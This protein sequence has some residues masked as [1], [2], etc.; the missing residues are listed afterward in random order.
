LADSDIPVIV[1]DHHETEITPTKYSNAIIINN[2]C[3]DYSN[4][5]LS[6]VGVTYQFCKY[7][8]SLMDTNYADNY[9]D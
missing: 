5:A 1:L 3:S 7:L 8:D 9:L 6:G 4:K 2:Q